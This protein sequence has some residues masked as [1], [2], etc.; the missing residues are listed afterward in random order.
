MIVGKKGKWKVEEERE[1][2]IEILKIGEC[3]VMDEIGKVEKD[4][5]RNNIEGLRVKEDI[6]RKRKEWYRILMI[7]SVESKEIGEDGEIGL[8]ELEEMDIGEEEKGEWGDLIEGERIIEE[9]IRIVGRRSIEIGIEKKMEGIF[10][11]GIVGEEEKREI[12]EKI[13]R[14]SE[15]EEGGEGEWVDEIIE[16]RKE[17]RRKLIIKR[18][19]KIGEEKLIDVIEGEGEWKKEIEKNIFKRK[20]E[21]GNK[22]KILIKVWSEIILKIEIEEDLKKRSKKEKIGLG[23]K[24]EIVDDDILEVEKSGEC[25]GIGGRKENE[26]ILNIIDKGWLRI[27]RR[28]LGRMMGRI[29]ILEGKRIE[30][31]NLRKIWNILVVVIIIEMI[32]IGGKE[33]V[34]FSKREIGEKNGGEWK[35]GGIDIESGEIDIGGMNMDW[36]GEIKDKLVKE[37]MIIIEKEEKIIWMKRKISGEDWLVRLMRIIGID[38]II[39]RILGKIFREE[40]IGDRV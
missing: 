35:V 2:L 7:K 33:E 38:R 4:E 22:I 37:G 28:R 30:G 40:N 16:R 20:F 29:D 14:K 34:E 11:L 15:G 17:K 27:E 31:E 32:N 1:E 23:N 12:E 5:R 3:E 26:K 8:I 21:I 10:E 18:I 19:K 39:K 6:E 24:I 13:K 9:R 25:W 36:N